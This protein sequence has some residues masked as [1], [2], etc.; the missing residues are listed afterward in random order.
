MQILTFVYKYR[1]I[2]QNRS[3]YFLTRSLS[4]LN[5]KTLFRI[6]NFIVEKIT[7]MCWSKPFT[8]FLL[9][10]LSIGSCT[11]KTTQI[12]LDDLNIKSF[13]E[14][15]PSISP[16]KCASGDTIRLGG[17]NYERGVGVQS[18]SV[19]SMSLNGNAKHFSA[20]VGADDK[21]NKEVQY[22]FFVLGDRKVLFESGEMKVGDS[23]SSRES[24]GSLRIARSPTS[25][26]AEQAAP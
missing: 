15:V 24:R 11:Q 4:Q 5:Y 25:D 23:P 21:A 10:F 18:L 7:N 1:T 16:K 2:F 22:S 20:V 13:S 14:G 8:F 19:L 26:R 3:F 6:N 17:K 12:W 9:I